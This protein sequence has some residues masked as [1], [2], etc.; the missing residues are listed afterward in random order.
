MNLL[1]SS[2]E[3]EVIH[4]GSQVHLTVENSD[5]GPVIKLQLSPVEPGPTLAAS[6]ASSLGLISNHQQHSLLL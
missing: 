5:T 1:A 2:Y 6:L 3:Q 4:K